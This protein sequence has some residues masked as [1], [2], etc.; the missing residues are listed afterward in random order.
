MHVCS[1]LTHWD[2]KSHRVLY[3]SV[4]DQFAEVRNKTNLLIRVYVHLKI[5][6]VHS[7]SDIEDSIS[8]QLLI[9]MLFEKAIVFNQL[10]IALKSILCRDNLCIF[11]LELLV[12][13]LHDVSICF[14]KASEVFV[15]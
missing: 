7:R 15:L 14:R 8:A 12:I 10:V 3:L 4:V 6:K 5:V 2:T 1:R 11:L 9:L 13:A